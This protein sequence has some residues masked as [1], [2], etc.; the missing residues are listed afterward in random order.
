MS[1]MQPEFGKLMQRV[2]EG[3]PTA[4]REL[5]ERYGHHII[6]IVRLKLDRRLRSKFDSIDFVQAVWASFFTMPLDQYDFTQPGALI[7]FLKELASNKVVEVIRQRLQTQRYNVT[8]EHSGEI[9]FKTMATREP[10]PAEL[11][12]AREEWEKLLANQPAHYRQ[13]LVLLRDGQS[14][15]EVAQELG[16]T[17]RTIQRVLEKLSSWRRHEST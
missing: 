4:A 12:M 11:A 16:L 14:Q 1:T 10:T 9:Q 2:Q 8:R 15:K 6:R 5:V 3:D 7:T 17:A 13:M